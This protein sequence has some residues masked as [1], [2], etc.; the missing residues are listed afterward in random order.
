MRTI[1]VNPDQLQ[2]YTHLTK[3]EILL[4]ISLRALAE[5]GKWKRNVRQFAQ[6]IGT[7]EQRV[8]DAEYGLISRGLL[9]VH[10]IRNRRWWYVSDHP[11]GEDMT[12]RALISVPNAAPGVQA[13]NGEKKRRSLWRKIRDAIVGTRLDNFDLE[14]Q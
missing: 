1:E 12:E 13:G 10:L 4:H 3:N 6:F 2:Q 8:R 5:D 14:E 11:V 7:S 9:R